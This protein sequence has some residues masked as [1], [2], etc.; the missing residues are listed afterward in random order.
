V[1]LEETNALLGPVDKLFR[2]GDQKVST[3]GHGA[4]P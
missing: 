4:T 3:V 1:N 2:V